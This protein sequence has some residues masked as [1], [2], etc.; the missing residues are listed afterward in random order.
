MAECTTTV[1]NLVDAYDEVQEEQ[2]W[3]RAKLVDMEDMSRHINVKL[4]GIPESVIPADLHKYASD[5]MHVIFPNA[6]PLKPNAAVD[7]SECDPHAL[8]DGLHCSCKAGFFGNGFNCSDIDECADSRTHNCS[9]GTCENTVGSYICRCPRGYIHLN[10]SCVP[11]TEC[12]DPSLY[13]CHPLA[14][15][16]YNIYRYTCVCPDGYYGGG[17]LCEIDECQ[18]GDCGFGTECYKNTGY[19][20]CSDPCVSHRILNNPWRGTNNT[21]SPFNNC[22]NY[23][24]GWY[25]FTGSGG[26]R[27]PEN[28]VPE[29]RCGTQAPVWMNGTHPMIRDGIVDRTACAHWYGDCCYRTSTIQVKACPQGYHVYKLSSNPGSWC[30]SSYCTD[31][32]TQ[33]C[34]VDEEWKLRNNRYGCFCKNQYKVTDLSQVVPD[35]ACG[36]FD[37]NAT[38]HKC[39]FNDLNIYFN[40]T[41]V[42]DNICFI[43]KDDPV[44]NSFSILA[45]IKAGGCG[46]QSYETND[47]H[48]THKAKIII[49]VEEPGAIILRKNT[50]DIT[51]QCVYVLDMIN[52]LNITLHPFISSI[53]ISVWW[54]G[55]FEVIMALYQNSGYTTPY[56]GSEVALSTEQFLYVGVFFLGGPSNL[57]LLM[58]NCYSTPT[59]NSNDPLKYYIIQ[60]S[61]PNLQDGTVSVLENGV[62]NKGRVSVKMLKFVGIY[63]KVYLHCTVSLCETDYGS[64]APVCSRSGSPS[65]GIGVP[66]IIDYSGPMTIGPIRR[67][68]SIPT[69]TPKPSS[70]TTTKPIPITTPKPS[71]PTT[72]SA[73]TQT[74]KADEEWQLRGSRYGCF[75]KDPYKVT[76]MY[77]RI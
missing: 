72:T 73:S 50:L 67:S 74:C 28:C 46:V 19:Y 63:D 11:I 69:S 71:S 33:T 77:A 32:S 68:G 21:L 24:S 53:N 1:N 29:N 12:E 31:A 5:L 3:T 14:K 23:M 38:F 6:T 61:C 25:R 42:R 18:R 43:F 44:T 47:T 17:S 64:C 66:R 8:C 51:R 55:T 58:K 37:M 62:S 70:P 35:L 57:V 60:N 40:K 48:V 9:V 36:A 54:I 45:P 27:L 4:R 7:C 76:G 41:H 59:N 56:T 2:S 30:Y 20:F 75:C 26:V 52:S 34:K 39:H 10:G 13:G 22:D 16:I 49:D 15:C 65:D